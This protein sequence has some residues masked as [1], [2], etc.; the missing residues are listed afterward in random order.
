MDKQV[1][2]KLNCMPK[3]RALDLYC[4]G[5]AKE[6]KIGGGFYNIFFIYTNN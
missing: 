4:P 6:E 2:S 3:F 5:R 1:G